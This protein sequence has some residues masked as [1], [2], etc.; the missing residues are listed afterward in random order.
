MTH[1][2]ETELASDALQRAEFGCSQDRR[3]TDETEPLQVRHELLEQAHPLL[4]EGLL[5]ADGVHHISGGMAARMDIALRKARL[6]RVRGIG[7]EDQRH[8]RQR[9]V[10]DRRRRRGSD[11]DTRMQC[12]E[13]EG[14]PRQAIEHAVRVAQC[15][16]VMDTF[17][18]TRLAHPFADSDD[19][20]VCEPDWPRHQHRNK[21]QFLLSARRER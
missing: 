15:K 13:L 11:D 18:E 7:C 6:D 9:L 17:R 20:V 19:P 10:R 5:A 8:L 1:D 16:C 12:T 21:R 14:K 4:S 2:L 3:R